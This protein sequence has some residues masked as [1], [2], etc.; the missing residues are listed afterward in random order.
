[1]AFGIT[2]DCPRES[3]NSGARGLS[4]HQGMRESAPKSAAEDGKRLDF[5][6]I[7]LSFG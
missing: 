2:K 5:F 7:V 1:L 6:Q 3:W 4:W